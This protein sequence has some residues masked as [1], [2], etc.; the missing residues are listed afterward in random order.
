MVDLGR[1][2]A[3]V[4]CVAIAA[5]VSQA[6]TTPKDFSDPVELLED[7]AR[8]YA[9]GVDTYRIESITETMWKSELRH[10]WRKVYQTVIKGPGSLYRVESRS[11]F[12]SMIQDSDGTDE[13]VYQI[14]GHV[15]VKRA[16]PE[17]WPEFFHRASGG[18]GEVVSA[19]HMRTSLEST[20]AGYKHAEMLPQETI[21]I[22]GHSF[23][24]YVVHVTSND[25]AQAPTADLYSDTTFWIDK[26]AL[27]FRK[28]V[29]HANTYIRDSTG[30]EIRIPVTEDTTTVYPVADFN[31]PV[32]PDTFMF[33]P[34]PDAKR[35]ESLEREGGAPRSSAPKVDLVGQLAPDVSFIAPDGTKVPLSSY[36]GKPLLLEFWATWCG[37]CLAAMPALDRIYAEV[38]NRGVAVVTVDQDRTADSA[39]KYLARHGYGWTNYHDTE[40]AMGHAF[41]NEG[42]PLTILFDGQGKVVYY[43][44]GADELALRKAIAA[45][46]P[47]LASIANPGSDKAP[48]PTSVTPQL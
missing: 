47:N 48:P 11:P 44:F 46:G 6:Q 23:P 10:E 1:R 27:I 7:V 37:P 34:P 41:K 19:W 16:L 31:Q 42:I 40:G 21:S 22:E 36:R 26:S 33:T 38:K 28:Q 17:N 20:A 29:R 8:T 4:L 45:L 43:H 13:W 24:C 2:L 14:E 5:I 32:S 35:V 3:V 9:M 30:P 15:Y 12:G 39:A 25:S 18:N